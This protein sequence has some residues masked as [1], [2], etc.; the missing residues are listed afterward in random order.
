MERA[1]QKLGDAYYLSLK[2]IPK[3]T[4]TKDAIRV[5]FEIEKES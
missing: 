3:V 4:V 1:F 5:K 2:D